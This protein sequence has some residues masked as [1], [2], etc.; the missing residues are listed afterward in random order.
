MF[1]NAVYMT[2]EYSIVCLKKDPGTPS[3]T[4]QGPYPLLHEIIL[5]S[6]LAVPYK[7]SPYAEMS[8]WRVGGGVDPN[9]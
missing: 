8:R 5:H 4:T 3:A 1:Q 6:P 9:L 7:L 2:S